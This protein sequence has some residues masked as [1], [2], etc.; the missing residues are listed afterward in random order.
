MDTESV[1]REALDLWNSG[2]LDRYLSCYDS[3]V[4]WEMSGMHGH[5]MRGIPEALA[6]QLTALPDYRFGV[7]QIVARGDCAAIEATATGTNTGPIMLSD[8]EVRPATGKRVTRGMVLMMRVRNG[9]ICEFREYSNE[10]SWILQLTQSPA[11]TTSDQST[12]SPK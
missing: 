11:S 2:Q 7:R 9:R 5:G 4:E 1:V 10:P 12:P 8:G 6:A 3:D